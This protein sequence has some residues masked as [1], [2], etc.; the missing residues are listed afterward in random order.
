MTDQIM[1]DR[2]SW[3][4]Y[5]IEMAILAAKRSTCIRRKVGA[6]L[7]RNNHVLSIGYNGAP[8]GQ[9]H[10]LTIGCLR[11]EMHI[12]SGTK[13][14]VCRAV[15]AEQNVIIQAGL[16]GVSTAHSIMYCTLFPCSICAKILIN[17]GVVCVKY[18]DTY[19][20]DLA[21]TYLNGNVAIEPI[22]RHSIGDE[23]NKHGSVRRAG[24]EAMKPEEH[25]S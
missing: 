19:T 16:H 11:D 9:A 12:P 4:E 15:H 6:V 8:S 14:E 20:D 21:L 25:V 18:L 1:T 7:V 23:S 2:I 24:G 17:A 3:D 22:N 10:C 5:F 13:Q